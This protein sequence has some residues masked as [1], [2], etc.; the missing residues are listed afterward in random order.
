MKTTAQPNPPGL[1]LS[2]PLQTVLFWRWPLE[3]MTYCSRAHG[4]RFTLNAMSHP[5]LVFLSDPQ[6]IRWVI[7]GTSGALHPGKGTETLRPVVGDRSFMLADGHRHL[8]G[9]KA[10]L[11]AFHYKQVEAHS[12]MVDAVVDREV[13]TWPRGAPVRLHPRLRRLTLEILLRSVLGSAA[14]DDRIEELRD[15]LIDMLSIVAGPSLSA[16]LLRHGPGRVSWDRFLRRQNEVNNLLFTLIEERRKAPAPPHDLLTMLLN[17]PTGT[18]RDPDTAEVRDNLMSLILAGHETT[19]S[20]LA[21]AFQLLV[22]HPQALDTLVA[23]CDSGV[24]DLYLNATIQE[25]LRHRPVFPFTIPRAVHEKVCIGDWTY[26][27]PTQ[28]L[29]CIFLLHHDQRFYSDPWDFRPERFLEDEPEPIAW[30]PWGGGLKRCPGL[31]MALLEM[32]TVIR[33]VLTT[34]SLAPTSA[35]MEHARW[36][37]VIVTPHAGSQVIL[38]KRRQPPRSIPTFP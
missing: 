26:H 12:R 13:R 10:A 17:N 14:G 11:A 31:H 6:E 34:F 1:G 5:P 30:I 21:W 15:R 7:T 16:P 37:S 25:V 27:A 38:N 24:T 20:E 23:E 33:K 4:S 28:L 35:T 29:G 19:A 18:T 8:A 22:H 3:Y 2:A 9:R 36:R 32:R